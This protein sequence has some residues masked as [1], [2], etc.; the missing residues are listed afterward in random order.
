MITTATIAKF[1]LDEYHRMIDAGVL[2]GRHVELLNGL[3]IEMAAE[4]TSHA[5][6]SDESADYLSDLLGNQAKVREGKPITLP[7]DSEPEPDIA[8]VEPLGAV[9]LEHHPYPENILLLIEYSNT[10]LTKDL[11]DKSLIYAAAA[12]QEYWVVNLRDMQLIVF[13]NPQDGVYQSKETL[14]AGIINPLAFDVA[15]DVSRLMGG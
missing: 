14:T 1:S 3:I 4:G 7:N 12:V 2:Q 15:I 9:Y 8:V 5:Y 10:S 13:R 11:E 6:Y